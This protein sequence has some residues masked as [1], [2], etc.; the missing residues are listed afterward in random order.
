MKNIVAFSG[1]H[2]TGKSTQAY[3]L[4][5]KLKLH[6]YNVALVD[7]LAREC[8]L[9]INKEAVDLTQYWI[10][11]S[12]IKREI[13]LMS[14]YDYVIV[15]RSIFDTLAYGV[16]LK[17]ISM[18]NSQLIPQYIRTYYKSIIVLDPYGFDYQIEDGVRDMDPSFRLAVHYNMLDL[19]N[20]FDIP[21]NMV[22]RQD[23]LDHYISSI[24]KL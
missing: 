6:G 1:T 21:Y 8:P 3:S 4:A 17:N 20:R 19:Y 2:G 14:R 5:S 15:D 12:Q 24:F 13:E 18:D 22:N 11:A 23:E 9:P 7:E 16:T 10:V